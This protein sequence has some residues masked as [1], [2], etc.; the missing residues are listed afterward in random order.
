MLFREASIQQRL[1]N[2]RAA[3]DLGRWV[4]ARLGPAADAVR[5][6]RTARCCACR[7]RGRSRRRTHLRLIEV[8]RAV[9]K[10][11]APF[12]PVRPARAADRDGRARGAVPHAAA[13]ADRDRERRRRALA[14]H[15]S[16]RR[17]TARTPGS[18]PIGRG[19]VHPWAIDAFRAKVQR[20]TAEIEASSDEFQVTA[21][22]DA[23]ATAAG[24][25]DAPPHAGCCCSAARAARC[26]SRS[27]SSP[28]PRCA[29]TSTTRAGA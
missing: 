19:D 8:G 17:S 7:A 12:A 9:L 11:D 13:V 26:C 1:V 15:R 6:R 25:V 10:P 21:P 18:C 2:L 23:L 14:Q 16:S 24:V 4:D 27:R 28:R 5:A 22:T 29:A 3:D 20:L